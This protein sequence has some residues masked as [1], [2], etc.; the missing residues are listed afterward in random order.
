LSF[1][2]L[3]RNYAVKEGKY[4]GI[5]GD[6]REG[7][8]S[9][10]A[11]LV[12]IDSWPAM[13]KIRN[14]CSRYSLDI[15]HVLYSIAWAMECYEKGLITKEDTGGIDLKFGNEDAVIELT[16]K[17]AHREGFGDVLAN[18]AQKAAEKIGKGTEKYLLTIK[19]RE[20]EILPQRAVYQMALCLA[21]CE[22]GPDHTRWYPPYP[23]NPKSIPQDLPLQF[24]PFKAFQVR[25]VEDKGR[26]VKWLYDSRAVL[27]SMPTCV[28]IVR[29]TLGIDMRPWLDI[30]NACTGVDYSL[31]EFLKCG[32]R[33]V[34]LE[35]A[36]IVREGFRRKDDTLPRR[37]LEDPIVDR[38]IP[39]IGREN[40]D[41]MLDDY[42]TLR[43]WDVNTAIP[44][45]EKLR[46]L[47]LDFVVDDLKNL[48]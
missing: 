26:L 10:G 4:A 29:D 34:N 40:L 24:D 36:Y 22:G 7:G 20:C 32:E 47:D 14:L 31:D 27:E 39:P 48:K 12:A 46:E 16:H 17:I 19:G 6:E 28:F 9:L 42:Y 44:K 43:G 13:L 5:A 11:A 37:E 8:F 41:R 15:Y 2:C 45:E 18:G 38:H 33:L 21:V 25:S 30:Y 1:S 35:R 23:P 3:W